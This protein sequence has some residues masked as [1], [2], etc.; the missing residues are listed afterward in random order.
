MTLR[1]RSEALTRVVVD[2]FDVKDRAR[3]ARSV[4]HFLSVAENRATDSPVE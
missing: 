3:H 2:P 1:G 4:R